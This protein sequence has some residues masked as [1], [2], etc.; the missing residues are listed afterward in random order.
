M[1]DF[2]VILFGL[3]I[4]SFLSVCVYRIPLGRASG[5]EEML[6]EDSDEAQAENQ[7][8]QDSVILN[9]PHFPQRV[10]IA[11]P[12]RSFCPHCGEQLKWYHN[13][14]LF[15][16]LFLRGKCGFCQAGISFR[17]P[18]TELLSA[19]FAWLSYSTFDTPTAIVAYLLCAAFLVLSFIDIEYFLLP[20][21]ITYP[22]TIIG[23]T[24]ALIQGY[25]PFIESPPFVSNI[26]E[27]LIGVLAGAG[28]LLLISLFYTYVRKKQ[29][30]G[31][32]DVKLLAVTGAFFGLNGA[33]YTIFVGSLLGSFLGIALLLLGR[34]KWSSY[35]PFGPYLVA[36][37]LLYLFYAE[38]FALIVEDIAMQQMGGG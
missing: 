36:A 2:A 12:P 38:Q 30:L 13:I 10:T 22:A 21:V 31:L 14:P 4:G 1:I 11:F 16:F 32:G 17:Y 6:E 26:S 7:S 37:N 34:G 18:L 8:E 24:I 29:G 27:A 28:S 33:F 25:A 23:L 20:N 3:I 19:V 35:L 15:S 5:I 9:S